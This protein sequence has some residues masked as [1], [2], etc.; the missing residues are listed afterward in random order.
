MIKIHN[1][2]VHCI[3]HNHSFIDLKSNVNSMWVIYSI[4]L[5]TEDYLINNTTIILIKFKNIIN[6]IILSNSIEFSKY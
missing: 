5:V 6:I 2:K 4:T 3:S 1:T